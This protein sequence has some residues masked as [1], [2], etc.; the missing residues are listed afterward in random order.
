MNKLMGFFELKDSGLPSVPWKIFDERVKMSK[1][2]LWTV[3]TAVDKGEDTN[4]PR[5]V[6]ENSDEAYLGAMR[7]YEYYKNIGMIVYYPYFIADKSGVLDVNNERIIIE[8]VEKDLWNFVTNGNKN[9]TII[10]EKDKKIY[11]GDT[12]FLSDDEID[13]LIKN[14]NIIK[15]KYRDSISEGYS[16]IAEWSFAYNT[17]INKEPIGD[18][19]L[20]FYELRSI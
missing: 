17:D 11:D 15:H 3:R 14:V 9:V 16:I 10:L 7:L 1:D 4:L 13:L 5:I 6:G 2:Y 19:Y 12:R 18:K 20:V 8:A